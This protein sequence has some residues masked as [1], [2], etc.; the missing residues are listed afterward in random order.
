MMKKDKLVRNL[1]DK[2]AAEYVD[3]RK[4]KEEERRLVATNTRQAHFE[5]NFKKRWYLITLFNHYSTLTFNKYDH[6]HEVQSI[7]SGIVTVYY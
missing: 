4:Q 5:K 6:R 7:E 1:L 2:A 3:M